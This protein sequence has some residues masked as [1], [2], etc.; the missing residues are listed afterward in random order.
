VYS[1]HEI[2]GGWRIY[3][4][5]RKRLNATEDIFNIY[6][7]KPPYATNVGARFIVHFLHYMLQ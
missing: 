6:I 3:S 5:Q 1:A 4:G 7:Q 2:V